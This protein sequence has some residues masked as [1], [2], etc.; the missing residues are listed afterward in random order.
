MS[1][2]C[3]DPFLNWEN[4]QKDAVPGYL[5]MF[6]LKKKDKKK[7]TINEVCEA[8]LVFIYVYIQNFISIKNYFKVIASIF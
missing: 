7:Q 1:V 2:L 8:C 4:V 6:L 5:S 3:L